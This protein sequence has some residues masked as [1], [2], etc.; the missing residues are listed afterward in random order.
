[1]QTS[2]TV[3]PSPGKDFSRTSPKKDT[4][5]PQCGDS[6]V[7]K[8]RELGRKVCTSCGFIVEEK[9]FTVN[10]WRA[11]SEE[12]ETDEPLGMGPPETPVLHDKG[13]ATRISPENKDGYGK[14]LSPKE[15]ALARKLRKWQ[16][17]CRMSGTKERS[18]ADAL[19]QVHRMSSQL[20]VPESARAV[21]SRLCKRISD[22]EMFGDYSIEVFSSAA[23]LAA[24][25]KCQLPHRAG[26]L[27]DLIDEDEKTV[28]RAYLLL[29]RRL[30]LDIQPLHAATYVQ[31]FGSRADLSSKANREASNI[32]RKAYE[33]DLIAG[34][35][36]STMA[37]AA[38]YIAA[39]LHDEDIDLQEI[40]D[41]TDKALSTLSKK[42]WEIASSL[43][44]D[45]DY[46]S[47][48]LAPIE[49]E[50]SPR[51]RRKG[52]ES[53]L[54]QAPLERFGDKKAK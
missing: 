25:K 15:V 34:E 32:V 43:G 10:Q 27:A 17:R 3:V 42:G 46:Q 9:D 19:G 53:D 13:L 8:D 2:E 35:A 5:C 44:I 22:E 54:E 21:A 1:M 30:K 39:S 31:E 12:E 45:I 16:K 29:T 7:V 14:P 20:G 47:W 18:L 24:C 40:G 49:N 33:K 38:I 11:S 50:E 26:D 37:A 36:P 28:R 41:A 4:V 51:E 6:S 52:C 48:I 23:L